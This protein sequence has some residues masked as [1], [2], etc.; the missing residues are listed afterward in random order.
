MWFRVFIVNCCFEASRQSNFETQYIRSENILT[1]KTTSSCLSLG[2]CKYLQGNSLAA[3]WLSHFHTFTFILSHFHTF[4]FTHFF[5]WKWKSFTFTNI[6]QAILK[7]QEDGE[8]HKLKVNFLNLWE[9]WDFENF[10]E[11]GEMVEAE[12]R[13]GQMCW[14]KIGRWSESDFT[15]LSF[16]IENVPPINIFHILSLSKQW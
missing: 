14:Y 9:C 2:Y 16:S 1:K 8:M 5:Q 12:A 10:F 13:R 3:G 6:F 11:K 4:I 7:L 15:K